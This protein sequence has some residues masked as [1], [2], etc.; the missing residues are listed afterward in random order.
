MSTTRADSWLVV[1]LRTVA[2]VAA[3]MTLVWE[4]TGPFGVLSA[5][6]GTSL[7]AIFGNRI[8]RGAVRLPVVWGAALVV[9][10]AAFGLRSL[11]VDHRFGVAIFGLHGT[12]LVSDAILYG[13]LGLAAAS[14]LRISAARYPTFSIL[15]LGAI[16]MSL[17]SAVSAHRD[18]NINRPR[19]LTDWVWGRG[20]DPVHFL[21][22]IGAAAF[23]AL[24]FATL[25]EQKGRSA[26]VLVHGAAVAMMAALVL[27]IV[28]RTGAKDAR[29][30]GGLLGSASASGSA[31]S[32]GSAQAGSKPPPS[33]TGS[34]SGQGQQAAGSPSSSSS[35]AGQASSSQQN[36]DLSFKDDY[37]S[38]NDERPVAVILLEDD[39]AP[40]RHYYYFRQTAFSQFNG[41]RLVAS[42]TSG[43]DDDLPVDYPTKPTPIPSA[44]KAGEHRALVHTTV[45]LLADHPTPFALESAIEIA[46]KPSPDPARFV[47]AYH[48]T[49]ASQTVKPAGLLGKAAGD[50]H[51]SAATRAAYL[52]MPT[53]PRY[54]ALADKIIDENLREDLRKDPFAQA[55]VISGWMGKTATYSLKSKHA[56]AGDPTA[57]FLF[58]DKVGYCVHFAHAVAYLLRARGLP[59]RVGAGYAVDEGRRGSGSSILIESKDGHA[60]AETYLEGEGWIVVDVAPEHSLDPPPQSPDRDLQRALGEM[61]RGDKTAGKQQGE[62]DKPSPIVKKL[63]WL[64]LGA[65]LTALLVLYAV[66]IWR[67]VIPFLASPQ[68]I[69]RVAYRAALDRLAEAGWVRERYETR[70]HF[71]ERVSKVSPSIEPLTRE[72]LGRAFGA[73]TLLPVEDMR[74]L[75]REAAKAARSAAPTWRVILGT[76]DP[77]SWT[78]TR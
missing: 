39:Y 35:S 10:A 14:A 7:A 11:I 52:G 76:L 46:P 70:E 4:L 2:L 49:S 32:G 62:D 43:M 41:A 77:L 38:S 56:T 53:D 78:R 6:V 25:R 22:Y 28:M 48:V 47:R 18:G 27:W 66:K 17:G 71:A 23:I 26:R 60:W 31:G 20:D 5:V 59:A 9:T 37:S 34:G 74:R 45:A 54:K 57:D 15:E 61:A 13:L 64:L 42:T 16:A 36:Q 24:F 65:I 19:A 30:V 51:W 33:G 72:H 8:A 68:Q 1:V 12:F 3:A 55:V 21:L 67:R 63:P 75:S 29:Q 73:K 69:P 44:P 50:S 58:G 40:P